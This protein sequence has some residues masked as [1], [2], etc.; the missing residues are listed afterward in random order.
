MHTLRP[1]PL[2]AQLVRICLCAL[3]LAWG[4][5]DSFARPLTLKKSDL[6][7]RTRIGAA[8]T[9]A[10]CF[11]KGARLRF[12][13]VRGPAPRG[14]L[15]VES[16]TVGS[17]ERQLARAQRQVDLRGGEASPEQKR[18][19]QTLTRIVKAI[20]TF[21]TTCRDLF[22]TEPD[23]SASP[24]SSP[25]ASGTPS[26]SGSPSPSASSSPVPTPT[27]ASSFQAALQLS[28]TS[29]V[30][31]LA[32]FADGE[33]LTSGLTGGD[34]LNA[35]FAIDFDATGINPNGIGRKTHGFLSG[36][37]YTQP[38]TYQ[39]KMEVVDNAGRLAIAPTVAVTV[40]NPEEVFMPPLGSTYCFSTTTSANFTGCPVTDPSKRIVTNSFQQALQFGGAN[41]RLLFRRGDIL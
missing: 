41:R 4:A 14:R 7:A 29:G 35:D 9:S 27:P 15:S 10:V 19:V 39:V 2:S 23:P 32:V 8:G 22:V 6:I 34:F 36:H 17:I 38:G 5:T 13:W 3:A 40:Q 18:R 24:S 30:A 25:Q 1:R 11:A 21:E 37:V 28:R 33:I 31:P 26:P 12:G 16:F 20:V